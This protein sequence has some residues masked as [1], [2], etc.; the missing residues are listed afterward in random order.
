M[1]RRG[2]DAPISDEPACW[3]S[4]ELELIPVSLAR[5]VRGVLVPGLVYKMKRRSKSSPTTT[6]ENAPDLSG[7]ASPFWTKSFDR[8]VISD[9]EL[10]LVDAVVSTLESIF[11]DQPDRLD[12]PVLMTKLDRVDHA[13]SLPLEVRTWDFVFRSGVESDHDVCTLLT[14]TFRELVQR[15]GDVRAALDVVV[16]GSAWIGPNANG[17]YGVVAP[18]LPTSID[19][20]VSLLR[21]R[22]FRTCGWAPSSPHYNV[23]FADVMGKRWSIGLNRA[24]TLQQCSEAIGMTRERMRQI[25]QTVLWE[26]APRMWG[27]ASV[28]D[29]MYDVL[30]DSEVES[31]DAGGV[32][33]DRRSAVD[34]LV[35]FGYP[36]EDFEAPWSVTD[37]LALHGIKWQDV[38]RFAYGESEKIGF[39]S[40]REL[41]HHLANRFPVLVGEMFDDVIDHLVMFNDL[42][43][44]FVYMENRGSS[45]VKGWL[46]KLF[47]VLGS[48]S[49][50]ETYKSLERFCTVRVPRL[51]FPPRAVIRAFL[52]RHP[53]FWLVDDVVGLQEPSIHEIDGVEKWLRTQIESC[54]GTVIHKTELWD[55]ARQDG[56]R[57]GT[58]NV[59]T[60][61]H[62]LFKPCG[63]GCITL[64]GHHPIAAAIEMAQIRARAIRVPTRRGAVR[65]ED[66]MVVVSLE[67]GN[68]VLDTGVVSST[69]EMRQMI[70]GQRFA[71]MSHGE[72]FGS[73]G[74][75]NGLMTGF[76]TVLQSMGVQPGDGVLLSFDVATSE[77]SVTFDVS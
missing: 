47:G 73:V 68:D 45:G 54:S 41:R 76:S 70:Q 48:Q 46:M 69:A 34:V 13:L 10:N 1:S 57:G 37:E 55:R 62:L 4:G 56:V 39:I 36:S 67:V 74:W 31:V 18:A 44:G 51:V 66:G 52:E 63:S 12:V 21:L 65:V 11:E 29:A 20:A 23:R 28:L 22:S 35:R 5:A 16:T 27:R 9:P 2:S 19:E 6:L 53:A 25:E 42:P 32:L 58:L 40:Q 50:D 77:V 8:F 33:F 75:S 26:S 24:W 3:G 61:Y 49:F 17:S 71:V 72:Q 15:L 43:H 59:Y 14:G 64:T 7:F 38:V 30:I 60:S